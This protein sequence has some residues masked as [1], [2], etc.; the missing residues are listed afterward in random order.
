MSA[1][2]LMPINRRLSSKKED[3]VGISSKKSITLSN[4]GSK[5]MLINIPQ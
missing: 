4:N 1:S 5:V 3:L 2:S